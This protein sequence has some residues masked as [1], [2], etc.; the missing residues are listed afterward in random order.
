M[1]PKYRAVPFSLLRR[2]AAASAA[3]AAKRST[4]HSLTEVDI[5]EPR[6]ILREQKLSLTAY[7]VACLARA[8]AENP[9]LNSL[10]KGRRLIL[11]EDVTVAVL[12]ERELQGERVPEPVGIQRAQA[13]SFRQIHEEIREHQ[14]HPPD[15]LGSL[16]GLSWVTLL[17]SFLLRAFMRLGSRS[18]RLAD[19]YGVV[20]VTAVGMFGEGALW[21]LPLSSATVVV[22][23]GSIVQR[24]GREH[25]CLTVS[26]DH[27][28]VDGAPAARFMR[29]LAELIRGG[30]LLAGDGQQP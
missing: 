30:Q 7:V 23:V 2:A 1:K 4:I 3:V 9:L 15:R 5:T 16:S 6:R 21:F 12:I 10:R 29:R 13:K 22:T 26:F 24:E 20:A 18:I 27:A 11:L 17:P 8:V 14:R 25:L 28:I 19:R